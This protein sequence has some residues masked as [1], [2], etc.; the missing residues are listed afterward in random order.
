MREIKFRGMGI[1]GTFFVGNL[2]II[3]K[4]IDHLKPG[5]F[6]S[7]SVG[8]PFAYQVRS[9]TIGQFTGQHDSNNIEIWEGDSCRNSHGEIGIV[10]FTNGGFWLKY[11]EP[12][13][14]DPMCPAELIN[15]G[16]NYEVIGNIYDNPE[17]VSTS[18]RGLD[19]APTEK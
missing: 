12:Y 3:L 5:S 8:M 2:A 10:V 6:I 7:N 14:W 9:E 16:S 1:D 11:I 17:L 15:R 4:R 13:D 18:Q 19:M